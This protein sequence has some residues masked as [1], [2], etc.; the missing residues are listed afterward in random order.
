MVA[1]TPQPEAAHALRD[2][3]LNALALRM[4]GPSRFGYV[5]RPCGR[6]CLM[7]LARWQRQLT[8]LVT[9]AR[10]ARLGRARV[11][12]GCAEPGEDVRAGCLVV[13]A[14]PTRVGPAFGT[15]GHLALPINSEV[16]C[17]KR[18]LGASLPA[19]RGP[20]RA[21]QVNAVLLLRTDE[22]VGADVG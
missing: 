8:A 15:A 12:V 2:R 5:A 19:G 13:V 3:S 18:T 1:G 21:D 4:Q 22:V 9:P 14:A 17:V 10:A 7:L 11:A 20:P 16:A 6:K